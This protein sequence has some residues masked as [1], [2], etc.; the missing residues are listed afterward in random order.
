MKHKIRPLGHITDDL[1]HLLQEMALDHELQMGEILNLVRGY[2]EIHLP[3]SRE[4]YTDGSHPVFYYG[5]IDY[6]KKEE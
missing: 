6:L 4:N 3:D 2:I 5:H 1:E